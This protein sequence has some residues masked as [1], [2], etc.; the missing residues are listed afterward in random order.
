MSNIWGIRGDKSLELQRKNYKS[1][2][3]G[4]KGFACIMVMIGHYIGLYKYA[5]NFPIQN[6][7]LDF[8]DTLLDSKIAF[9]IDENFWVMLFFVVSGYLVAQSN[10]STFTQLIK[11]WV[12]RFLRLGLPIFFASLIIF[13]ISETIEFQSLNTNELFECRFVQ[14][15]YK[16]DILFSQVIVSPFTVLLGG[17]YTINEP[18]WCLR[19]M[20]ATSLIIY[21][22]TYLKSK[23]KN[24]NIYTFLLSILFFASLVVSRV[25][26]AGFF[27]MLIALCE[28][29]INICKNKI[30][31]LST[32]V[33][34]ASIYF[35]SR[36]HISCIFF[37][38]LIIFVPKI[39][40]LNA[41][42][43]SK[44]ADIANKI[45][46]GIYSFHW[47]ILLSCGML[48]LIKTYNT[49]GL[50]YASLISVCSSII[51]S[52]ILSVVFYYLIEQHI[53]KLL[54]KIESC[55][56]KQIQVKT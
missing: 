12:M 40:C 38:A 24:E 43:S 10:V 36:K 30:F 7:F 46:F 21:L 13:L 2:I 55:K 4:L 27:G 1:Y 6:K 52:I 15:P 19:E 26:F 14:K 54:R 28:K 31:I 49:L 16:N 33:F 3:N 41:I 47:P 17:N 8:F 44:I 51:I 18:Y 56:N 9:S 37:S 11:K 29:N 42:F 53:Y 48:I 25:V 34:C 45:S 22:L 39:S 23:I 32:I 35:L 50:F 20:F 5:E